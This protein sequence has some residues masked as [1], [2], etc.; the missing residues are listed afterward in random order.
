[1]AVGSD[2]LLVG[3]D[4]FSSAAERRTSDLTGSLGAANRL[5]DNIHVFGDERRPVARQDRGGKFQASVT[6]DVAD[7]NARDLDPD[8]MTGGNGFGTIVEKSDECS[9]DHAAAGEADANCSEL[10]RCWRL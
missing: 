7:E 3:R 9:A 1:M 5:D 6:Q 10:R 4:E 2:Q 8:A